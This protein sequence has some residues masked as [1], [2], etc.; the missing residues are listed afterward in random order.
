MSK[1]FQYKADPNF[2]PS[3]PATWKPGDLV[4]LKDAPDNGMLQQ[5]VHKIL[6]VLAHENSIKIMVDLANSGRW[7][8][9]D[10]VLFI[11]R[12]M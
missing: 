11:A 1:I 6:K 7:H 2:D 3:I 4:A 12:P 10:E 8:Q 5:Q 9:I